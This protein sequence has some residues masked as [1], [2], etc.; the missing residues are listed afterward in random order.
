MSNQTLGTLNDSTIAGFCGDNAN[1]PRV[2]VAQFG[3]VPLQGF[4]ECNSSLD[5]EPITIT[6]DQGTDMTTIGNVTINLLE[7][8]VRNN[9]MENRIFGTILIQVA[10]HDNKICRKV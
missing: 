9:I 8:D 3:G 2:F 4:G 5:L 6:E 7:S 10:I 1:I